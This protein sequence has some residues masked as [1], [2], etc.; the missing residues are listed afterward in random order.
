MVMSSTNGPVIRVT[1][2]GN[3]QVYGSYVVALFHRNAD[4]VVLNIDCSNF[5]ANAAMIAW[6]LCAV[7]LSHSFDL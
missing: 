4:S 1:V 2:L 6:N 7:T 5:A 3:Y